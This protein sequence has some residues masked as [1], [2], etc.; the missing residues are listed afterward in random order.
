MGSSP[1]VSTALIRTF[2]FT[3]PGV[4]GTVLRR[5]TKYGPLTL[6]LIDRILGLGAEQPQTRCSN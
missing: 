5:W 2:T 3:R 1:I 6:I 4:V